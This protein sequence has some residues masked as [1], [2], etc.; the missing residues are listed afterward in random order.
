MRPTGWS[1][2]QAAPRNLG[3]QWLEVS[4]DLAAKVCSGD[5][6]FVRE[7]RFFDVLAPMKL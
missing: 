3:S 5:I 4:E 6:S 1:E 7:L 2:S